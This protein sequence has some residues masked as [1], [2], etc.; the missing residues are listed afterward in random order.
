MVG[1]K[2][3]I[4][5]L[6]IILVLNLFVDPAIYFLISFFYLLYVLRLNGLKLHKTYLPGFGW[7]CLIIAGD[8]FIGLLRG[9]NFRDIIRDMYYIFPTVIWIMIGSNLIRNRNINFGAILK[10]VYVFGFVCSFFAIVSFFLNGD[11]S[12]NGLRLNFVKGVYEAGFIW[13]YL[14]YRVFVERK[15]VFSKKV[16][17][18]MGVIMAVHIGFSLG[19][20]SMGLPIIGVLVM[21]IL[22]FYKHRSL[23]TLKKMAIFLLLC[24][25]LIAVVVMVMPSDVTAF[26]I[27]KIFSSFTEINTNQVINSTEAAMNNWRAYENQMAYNTFKNNNLFNQIFGSGLGTGVTVD[28][29]PY[30]WVGMLVDNKL[31]LLHNGFLTALIKLGLI[32]LLSLLSM[33]I[34]P[35]IRAVR[36]MRKTTDSRCVENCIMIATYSIMGLLFTYVVRGPIEQGAFLM[37]AFLIGALTVRQK[38]RFVHPSTI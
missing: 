33:F 28:Y 1:D 32:G 2:K 11:W 31:P 27:Q 7:Y 3:I 8:I 36:H 34:L 37:W 14:M 13:V 30:S 18:C 6:L 25:L 20:I 23:F 22:Y 9:N 26:F 12:F 19:R 5:H 38:L 24:L 21:F 16:D 15:Y 4:S 10:T 29:V 17:I 35:C